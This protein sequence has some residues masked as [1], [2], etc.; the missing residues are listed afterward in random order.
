M[1]SAGD[2][3][4]K[5]D[6][7]NSEE[8]YPQQVGEQEFHDQLEELELDGLGI[9]GLFKKYPTVCTCMYNMTKLIQN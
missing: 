9:D 3:T 8:K 1:I 6:D 4:N 5:E 2:G 7:T